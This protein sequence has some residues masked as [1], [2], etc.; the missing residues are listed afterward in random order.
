M[1]IE[2]AT[3]HSSSWTSWLLWSILLIHGHFVFWMFPSFES[4]LSLL[5]CALR[6]VEH[7]CLPLLLRWPYQLDRQPSAL[8]DWLSSQ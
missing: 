8:W 7:A 6:L 3:S 4:E 2:L 5:I 1:K